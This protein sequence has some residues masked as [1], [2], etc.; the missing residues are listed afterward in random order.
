M[1]VLEQLNPMFAARAADAAML[2]RTDDDCLQQ[3]AEWFLESN[4]PEEGLEI[5]KLAELHEAVASRVI[6]SVWGNGLTQERV[7]CIMELCHGEGLAYVHIPNGVVRRDGGRLW[8]DHVEEIPEDAM[9]L[10]D[11]GEIIFGNFCIVWQNTVMNEEVHN[12]FNTFCLKCENITGAV[13][14]TSRR[15]GDRVKLHGH[16]HTKRL[17][18]LFQE[19][20]L[21]QPQRAVT[22]VFRDDRG[23]LAIFGFGIAQ[24]C[25]PEIGDE[26]IMINCENEREKWWTI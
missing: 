10:G 4:S 9:L 19:R 21:T 6:R 18:H 3:Q 15:D 17:K 5:G 22:P 16:S 14:V 23:I 20:K 11:S 24:R 7:R 26:I 13:S 12:S 2:L 1:P 25:V 8:T